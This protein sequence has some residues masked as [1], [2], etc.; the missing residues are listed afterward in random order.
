MLQCR[1]VATCHQYIDK[2]ATHRNA[3]PH[4]GNY[5]V[6]VLLTYKNK[7]NMQ[8]DYKAIAA[9]RRDIAAQV[10]R[11][12]R[13]NNDVNGN[14]RYYLPLYAIRGQATNRIHADYIKDVLGLVKY[15]GKKYGAGYVLQSYNIEADALELQRLES[16]SEYHIQALAFLRDTGTRLTIEKAIPQ[17]APLWD[18]PHGIHYSVTLENKKG[19]YTFDFWDSLHNKEKGNTPTEYDVLAAIGYDSENFADFCACYGYD[20]DSITARKTYD[21]VKRES[22]GLRRIFTR[23]QRARLAE[24][25]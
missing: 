18:G 24:I 8:N 1:N 20:T 3:T 10:A 19:A 6:V 17:R 14:P 16:L 4:M 15:R 12:T 9:V 25:N 7:T 13:I 2:L 5:G 22:E 23:A 21:A 11:F